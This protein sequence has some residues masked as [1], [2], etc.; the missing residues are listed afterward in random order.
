MATSTMEAAPVIAENGSP[1]VGPM[2]EVV[3]K[4]ELLSL[5]CKRPYRKAAPACGAFV[6]VSAR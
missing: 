4:K 6:C 2:F 3:N 5:S 1:M